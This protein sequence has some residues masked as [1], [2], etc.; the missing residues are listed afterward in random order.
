MRRSAS[1]IVITILLAVLVLLV[2]TVPALAGERPAMPAFGTVNGEDWIDGTYMLGEKEAAFRQMAAKV[3]AEALIPSVSNLGPAVQN[4][5][6]G[7][8][9]TVDVSNMDPAHAGTYTE[10]FVVQSVGTHGII[11]ITQAAYLSWD[12]TDYEF[13]NP[14][15]TGASTW[16]RTEDHITPAQLSYM[17]NTFDTTIWNT[18]S[19]IFG[20]PLARGAEGQKVWI[21]IYNLIDEA[22]YTPAATSYVAGYFSSSEDAENNK[23][24]IHIDTYDWAH[25]IGENTRPYLY[26]GVFAHEY[27]HLLHADSDPDEDSWVDEGMADLAAFLCGFMED[28]GHVT[29]YI[30][31]HPYTALTFFRGE[32]ADYGAC[33][34]FQLY[35]WENYGG[36]RFTSALFHDP[37]NG[38]QGVQR[39]LNRYGSGVKFDKVFDNWTLANYFDSI[40]PT[41]YGY[42]S[43]DLGPD[44]GG[45]TI[46]YMLDGF[47][48]PLSTF[49]YNPALTLPL[50]TPGWWFYYD[51]FSLGTP[52]LPYTAHYYYF[53]P[54]AGIKLKLDGDD[55]SGV[56]AHSGTQQMMS[57]TGTWAWKSF[58]QTFALPAGTSTLSFWTWYEIEA[59]GDP[60][61]YGYIEVHDQTAGQWYTVP[62]RDD[63]NALLT[64]NVDPQGQDNPNVPSGR[65]PSDYLDAGRWNAFN[66][67]SNGWVHA[68]V[69]LSSFA[70]HTITIYF[71]T[72][73]DGA[74]TYQ[75]MYV[76]DVLVDTP[77][78]DHFTDFETGTGGWATPATGDTGAWTHGLGLYGN[79]WQGTLVSIAKRAYMNPLPPSAVT[80][81]SVRVFYTRM[82]ATTQSGTIAG[83]IL[84]QVPNWLYVVSNRAEHILRADY[85]LSARR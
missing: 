60:W 23:N 52:A 15:G 30:Q 42:R 14:N 82:N 51:Y 13:A 1:A 22:Y 24:M 2:L 85:F 72:W 70:G 74:V 83:N 73:Q 5:T 79:D 20:T 78:T 16:L 7:D 11:C 58:H 17:L 10:T 44:T 18:M 25:R 55:H 68:N 77:G 54:Y 65:E 53:N 61:D 50:E 81:P 19:S 45:W 47:Y 41:M 4:A 62:A 64:I 48:N 56:A 33:Y 29:E 67:F 75:M 27:E 49:P 9:F 6:V 80:A 43:I 37:E 26:E 38:I 59:P 63:S 35:L 57:G 84:R 71:R 40:G 21:L 28:T 3:G 34:L 46:P 32:L 39:E 12:G 31:Y 66:G 76:D 69:D 36:D 8:V